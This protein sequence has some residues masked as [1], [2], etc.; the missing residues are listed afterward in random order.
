[1]ATTFT[2]KLIYDKDYKGYVAEVVNLPGCMS[3]GKT[4]KEA[5]SNVK[6]AIKAF[7]KVK[8]VEEKKEVGEVRNVRVSLPRLFAAA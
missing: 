2:I 4:K 7:L 3:Q 5:I 1:M 6:K 8:A